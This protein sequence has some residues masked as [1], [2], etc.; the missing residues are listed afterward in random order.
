MKDTKYKKYIG[1]YIIELDYVVPMI[2]ILY[3]GQLIKAYDCTI[4]D[5]HDRL[6][7][8]VKYLREVVDKTKQR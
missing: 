6:D 7:Q 3:E 8:Y 5:M 1:N 2:K 4:H